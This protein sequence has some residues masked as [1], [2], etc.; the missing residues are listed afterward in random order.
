MFNIKLGDKTYEGVEKVKL[1]TTDGGTAT[2][3]GEG[4]EPIKAFVT[5]APTAS[6]V[7]TKNIAAIPMEFQHAYKH[8]NTESTLSVEFNYGNVGDTHILALAVRTP[9]AEPATPPGWTKTAWI[10]PHENSTS[11][12]WL[13]VATTV[14]TESTAGTTGTVSFNVVVGKRNYLIV[15]N[16]RDFTVDAANP[17][18]AKAGGT[19]I[20]K[21]DLFE[22]T[23]LMCTSESAAGYGG[24]S[25]SWTKADGGYS[26]DYLPLF[27]DDREPGGRLAMLYIPF[28]SQQPFSK[29]NLKYT[30]NNQPSTSILTCALNVTPGKKNLQYAAI[31]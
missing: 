23:L 6:E 5:P 28:T 9:N 22:N 18:I 14:T 21:T 30:N 10:S 2:F 4:S 19:D 31:L 15:I 20:I 25:G 26:T 1:N 29:L 11:D 16:A 17:I 27:G 13:F 8:T 24:G 12:Q 7:V 3:I